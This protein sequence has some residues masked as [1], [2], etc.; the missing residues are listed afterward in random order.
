MPGFPTPV[1]PNVD[2]STQAPPL[3]G[4]TFDAITGTLGHVGAS[5]G[6]NS[7]AGK[8]PK[9]P[10]GPELSYSVDQL[11][12]PVGN[13]SNVGLHLNPLTAAPEH[14][15][16]SGLKRSTAVAPVRL[17]SKA[18]IYPY[19]SQGLSCQGADSTVLSSTAGGTT[20][21][22]DIRGLSTADGAEVWFPC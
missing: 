9:T 16:G 7:R 1:G 12:G 19:A 18:A 20:Y 4:D 11:G 10:M 15:A 21:C 2:P 6:I 17:F 22:L 8:P 5:L 13:L 14:R 3:A